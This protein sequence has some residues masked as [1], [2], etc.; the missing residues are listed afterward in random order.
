MPSRSFQHFYSFQSVSVFL[1]S[2]QWNEEHELKI[3]HGNY[4]MFLS[5]TFLSFWDIGY[6]STIFITYHILIG[7]LL[8]NHCCNIDAIKFIKQ[9]AK[10]KFLRWKP[11]F[12]SIHSFNR[13]R[14]KHTVPKWY[15]YLWYVLFSSKLIKTVHISKLPLLFVIYGY[16]IIN[17]TI[18]EAR[19][20]APVM[21][22]STGCLNSPN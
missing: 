21:E 15:S 7:K 16:E 18:Y 4:L 1:W 17:F 8:F 13:S 12:L 19:L 11:L 9:V 20:C 14:L 2:S 6:I 3:W 22:M 5:L 10:Y